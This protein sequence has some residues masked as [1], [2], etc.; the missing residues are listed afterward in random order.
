MYKNIFYSN[1][2]KIKRF[3]LKK[4]GSQIKLHANKNFHYQPQDLL[5]P[6]NR[7]FFS[8]ETPQTQHGEIRCDG[9]LGYENHAFKILP[10]LRNG[11]IISAHADSSFV[12]HLKQRAILRGTLD[13]TSL[14]FRKNPCRFRIDGCL[15]GSVYSGTEP[16]IAVDLPSGSYELSV[17]AEVNNHRAHTGWILLPTN[18][19]TELVDETNTLFAICSNYLVDVPNEKGWALQESSERAG[20]H[21]TNLF[22]GGRWESNYR[23][24]I[25]DLYQG[26]QT[27]CESGKKFVLF[28]DVRDVVLR[29]TKTVLLGRL[30]ELWRN[31][32]SGKILFAADASGYN[33]P[34]CRKSWRYLLHERIDSV[35]V[36]ANSGTYFGNLN[37]VLE[38]L[39]YV[40]N[41]HDAVLARTPFDDG[42]RY[43][44]NHVSETILNRDQG[45][46]QLYHLMHPEK[47]QLDINKELFACITDQLKPKTEPIH[48]HPFQTYSIGNASLIHAPLLS[49]NETVWKETVQMLLSGIDLL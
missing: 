1:I 32:S 35:H 45:Y 19:E 41:A 9:Q 23:H 5:I 44:V 21:W 7:S 49:W 28:A 15:L 33:I 16:T 18:N 14:A 2:S 46:V 12:L 11:I 13:L 29:H 43:W 22:S 24:K 17:Q 3:L 39:R 34:V 47:I 42:T 31:L 20:I 6:M 38:M 25:V 30:N 48:C 40:Q 37:N 4:L 36:L 8:I 27:A 10:S 26:Y